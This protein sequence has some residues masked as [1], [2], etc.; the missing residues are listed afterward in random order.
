MIYVH[1]RMD[2]AKKLHFVGRR[3]GVMPICHEFLNDII[4]HVVLELHIVNENPKL[5]KLCEVFQ[6]E[7]GL[8]IKFSQSKC[9]HGEL[10]QPTNSSFWRIQK[11][12]GAT[13]LGLAPSSHG[14]M[15]KRGLT[16]I[17]KRDGGG[18][19]ENIHI[20]IGAWVPGTHPNLI[21]SRSFHSSQAITNEEL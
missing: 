2:K 5:Y 12:L 14:A 18:S 1:V 4:L 21:L 19:I 16:T 17:S 11:S 7:R 8:Q 9:H 20:I 13:S 15:P 10:E 3:R 6:G